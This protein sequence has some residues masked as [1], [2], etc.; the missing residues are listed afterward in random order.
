[1]RWQ[2]V[3]GKEV[4]NLTK[5]AKMNGKLPPALA[6]QP[7]IDTI[8]TPYFRA[9]FSLSS[10]RQNSMGAELPIQ[11]SEILAYARIHN[12]LEDIQFLFR[13][14]TECDSI[15]FEELSKKRKAT[16][17]PKKGSKQSRRKSN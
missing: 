3:W 13:V 16:D 8:L 1:M 4:E 11:A 12:F 2:L 17:K 7:I 6:N 15:F 5:M 14:I 10:I 9:F